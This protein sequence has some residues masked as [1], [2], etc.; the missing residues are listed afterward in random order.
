MD[1]T[2]SHVKVYDFTPDEAEDF[3]FDHDTKS[4]DILTELVPNL[5]D[6]G[7]LG[8]ME[9]EEYE[10]NS[11]DNTLHLTL[12]T[13]W[14]CPIHWLQGASK[15]THYFENKLITMAT[16]QKDETCVTG[17]VVMDGE[18]LQNK[19]LFEMESEEVG[20]YYSEDY[21]DYELNNLDNQIWDSIGKFA[22]VCEQFYLKGD[23]END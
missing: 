5:D 6:W 18:V 13:K 16:V 9:L 3:E 1:A 11:H 15:G 21:P 14:R 8:W 7:G 23:E 17:V 2:R 20:K 19:C 4:S 22:T 10:Y 12:E